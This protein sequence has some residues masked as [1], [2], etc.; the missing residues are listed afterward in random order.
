MENLTAREEHFQMLQRTI[1]FAAREIPYYRSRTASYTKPL[2]TLEDLESLPFVDPEN[3][4]NEPHSFCSSNIWPDA[5]SFSSSTTGIIGRPRWHIKAESK[6]LLENNPKEGWPPGVTLVIHPFDQGLP[7]QIQGGPRNIFVPFF[8]PWHYDLILDAL[9]HGWPDPLGRL[10]VN[11][12]LAFSPALRILTAWLTDRNKDPRAFGVQ[13]LVG[14]GSIQPPVWRRRLARS[15]GANYA[16]LYG[17][18]EVKAVSG[19]CRL[20]CCRHFLNPVIPEV[21]DPVSRRVIKRGAGVLVLTELMPFAQLQILI[22]YWTADLVEI[23]E[24]CMLSSFG[25][26]FRGRLADSV[27]TSSLG[28]PDVT[29]GALQVGE[30]CSEF[31]DISVNKIS[32]ASSFDDVGSPRFF[33][34]ANGNTVNIAVELRFRPEVFPERSNQLM[35][36]LRR[37]VLQEITGLAN[38]V[39][40]GQV[41][42]EITVTRP[43]QL[44][45]ITKV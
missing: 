31:A 32:W 40:K 44:E 4:V 8:V 21:V 33:L 2:G 25:F 5:V 23:T 1:E 43:G 45:K 3:F 17:L 15:W 27:I 24:P 20:C 36:S 11:Y 19:T 6:A 18:S 29:I 41:R 30:I 10:T 38:A 12:I 39:D 7:L 16:D 35:H 42:L 9:E 13:E 22:R 14:Y 37:S 26:Q 34:S 28:R